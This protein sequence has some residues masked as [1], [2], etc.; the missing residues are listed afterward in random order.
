MASSLGMDPVSLL[1]LRRL[2]SKVQR[3]TALSHGNSTN[4]PWLNLL[5]KTNM[6]TEIGV[7]SIW[8]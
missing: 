2:Y 4:P 5:I 8:Q 3:S 7:T 6:L 1:L